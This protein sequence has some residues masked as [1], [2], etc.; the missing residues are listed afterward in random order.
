MIKVFL[1]DVDGTLTDGIYQT[2]EEGTIRKNFYTRDFHGMWM[3]WKSGVEVGI[4]SY[5]SDMVIEHQCCRGAK[6]A[7]LMNGTKDKRATTEEQFV[8]QGIGWNEICY[9]GD[10]VLDIELMYE[11]GVVACPADADP[12]ILDLMETFDDSFVCKYSGGKGCVREF[13]DYIR[14]TNKITEEKR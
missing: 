8:G 13:A 1:S 11:V 3:L 10:D 6:Y 7:V 5:A 9:I 14:E 12:V 4:I 2:D